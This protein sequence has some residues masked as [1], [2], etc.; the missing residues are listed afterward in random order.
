MSYQN[1]E[2]NHRIDA[3]TGFGLLMGYIEHLTN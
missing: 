2:H 1:T 3:D